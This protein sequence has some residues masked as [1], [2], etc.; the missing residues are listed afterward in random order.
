MKKFQKSSK[1]FYCE[2]CDYSSNRESQWRRHLSTT[3]HKMDNL[4]NPVDNS[5]SSTPV[6]K[7]I[8]GKQYKYNSGL[9]KHKKKCPQLMKREKVLEHSP[10]PT[11][12]SDSSH[13]TVEMFNKVVQQNNTLMEKLVEMSKDRQVINYQNCNNKK[14]TNNVFLNE[15]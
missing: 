14:M 1:K 9:S 7:C 10:L 8:C 2:K 15:Q 12:S 3:K 13:L 5:Q 6:F 4:D 11:T